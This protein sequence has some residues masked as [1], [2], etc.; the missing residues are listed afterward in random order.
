MYRYL[1]FQGVVYQSKLYIEL[2]DADLI[3]KIL[4]SPHRMNVFVDEG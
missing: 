4:K 1:Q 2:A 3:R